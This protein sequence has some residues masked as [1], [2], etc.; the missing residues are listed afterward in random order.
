MSRMN[1]ITLKTEM[2]NH[3][4]DTIIKFV[5]SLIV[6]VHDLVGRG[7][8]IHHNQSSVDAEVE[9]CLSQASILWHILCLVVLL[10][11]DYVD[12]WL[13]GNFSLL[14]CLFYPQNV[15]VGSNRFL[16]WLTDWSH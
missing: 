10:F 13:M 12:F 15:L 9:L 2:G 14:D 1:V 7:L 6:V 8:R 11:I 5:F 4:I 16:S 3:L